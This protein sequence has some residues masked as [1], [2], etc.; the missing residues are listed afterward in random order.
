METLVIY[1][2]PNQ[3]GGHGI[4]VA[5]NAIGLILSP[6]LM[7]TRPQKKQIAVMKPGGLYPD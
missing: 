3:N 6:T 4:Q 2:A 1:V 5:S 7:D